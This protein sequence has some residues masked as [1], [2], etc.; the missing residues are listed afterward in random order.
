MMTQEGRLL[1]EDS[2][3]VVGGFVWPAE[4]ICYFNCLQSIKKDVSGS[5]VSYL[6]SSGMK[7]CCC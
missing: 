3:C 2:F 7:N 6:F 4:V 1:L 5:Q